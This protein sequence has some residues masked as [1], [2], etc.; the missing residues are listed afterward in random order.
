MGGH[1]LSLC[2]SYTIVNIYVTIFGKITKI[3][4]K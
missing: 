4:G 1:S 2:I 3:F